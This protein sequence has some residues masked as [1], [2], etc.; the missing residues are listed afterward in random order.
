MNKPLYLKTNDMAKLIGYS[1]DYL[2]KNREILFFKGVHFFP[3]EKRID[4]K[5]DKMIEWVEGNSLSDQ[6]KN[7]LDLVS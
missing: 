1:G 5:V 6:A 4:W 2:L 7:I 3:K